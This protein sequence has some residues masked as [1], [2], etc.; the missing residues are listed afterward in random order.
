M[1]I[2]NVTAK[3]WGPT[4]IMIPDTMMAVVWCVVIAATAA[5]AVGGQ[6][7]RSRAAVSGCGAGLMWFVY[8]FEVRKRML[9]V[10]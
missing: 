7:V 8:D 4:E 3:K 5:G 1:A 6:M 10:M 2:V 9:M